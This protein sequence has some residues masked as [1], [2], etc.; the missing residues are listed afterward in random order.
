MEKNFPLQLIGSKHL[1]LQLVQLGAI[2]KA[3]FVWELNVGRTQHIVHLVLGHSKLDD[4]TK[5]G[6]CVQVIKF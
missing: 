1:L 5:E 6:Y 2:K 4:W 3:L